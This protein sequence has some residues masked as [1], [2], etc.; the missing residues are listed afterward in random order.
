MSKSIE[1]QK[2]RRKKVR[3]SLKTL[4]YE[5]LYNNQFFFIF[6]VR[7]RVYNNINELR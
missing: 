7:V 2:Q 3:I 5:N 6:C 4:F 1:R